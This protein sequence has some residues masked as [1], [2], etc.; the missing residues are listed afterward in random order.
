[1][2]VLVLVVYVLGAVMAMSMVAVYVL[3]AVVVEC[4]YVVEDM[5]LVP[6]VQEEDQEAEVLDGEKVTY[7]I[8]KTL[9][10]G[11]RLQ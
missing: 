4:E 3:D 10:E 6:E 8:N 9:S 5:E 1:M 11:D 2:V 7:S